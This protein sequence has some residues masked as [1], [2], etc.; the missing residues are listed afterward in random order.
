MAPAK[1]DRSLHRRLM[2]QCCWSKPRTSI[3]PYVYIQINIRFNFSIACVTALSSMTRG[4]LKFIDNHL[5]GKIVYMFDCRLLRPNRFVRTHARKIFERYVLTIKRWQMQMSASILRSSARAQINNGC[6]GAQYRRH[7]DIFCRCASV[8]FCQQYKWTTTVW[9]FRVNIGRCV[10]A[11]ATRYRYHRFAFNGAMTQWSVLCVSRLIFGI[12][13]CHLW[14]IQ[15]IYW[16][17]KSFSFHSNEL[18]QDAPLVRC[19]DRNRQTNQTIFNVHYIIQFKCKSAECVPCPTSAHY[20][21]Y[22]INNIYS[23]NQF[24][25][26]SRKQMNIIKLI[27]AHAI[28]QLIRPVFFSSSSFSFPLKPLLRHACG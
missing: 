22:N 20:I 17:M 23:I 2:V 8:A 16:L 11:T 9:N 10:E 13:L 7:I 25:S 28:P 26:E 12:Q 5:N 19:G 4:M 6:Y 27:A 18:M 15:L 1:W 24:A 14:Y 21:L 3:D